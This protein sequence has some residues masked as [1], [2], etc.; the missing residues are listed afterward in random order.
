[1]NSEHTTSPEQ[2]DN[3]KAVEETD[4]NQV[5]EEENS[6]SEGADNGE[7]H[8]AP[9]EA[10]IETEVESPDVPVASENIE[11]EESAVATEASDETMSAEVDS[12]AQ[13]V[14]D[15]KRQERK[16]TEQI[17]AKEAE[18]KRWQEAIASTQAAMGKLVEEGVSELEK[19][20]KKLQINVEQL[21]R[22]SERIKSEMRTN[23]AGVSQ[24]LAIRI[25][26]FKD[27]L[28]GSLQELASAAEQ[29]QLV[30]DRDRTVPEKSE[31]YQ[32]GPAAR[33]DRRRVSQEPSGGPEFGSGGFTEQRRQIRRILDQYR[34][35]PD[36]YGPA[37]QLRRTFEPIHAERVSNWFFAQGGKG[38]VPSMG[39]RLQNILITSAVI[40]VL[41]SLYG[42][43]LR[44]LILVNSPERL[45]EWRRGLQ[46]CLG[47]SR[48]DFGSDRG[49]VL[50]EEPEPLAVKAKRLDKQGELPLIVVDE[51]ENKVSLSMLQF[52]L[53][54]AFAAD[55]EAPPPMI[56]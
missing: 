54:L 53:W 33:Q 30:P 13:R 6:A 45:G 44:S 40:S 14:A 2:E 9:E 21:E 24:D 23:F 15:L 35:Q 25:Q 3:N 5:T 48:S 22:R 56:Y 7:E 52:L 37:W 20:K 17:A 11:A 41:R 46:D 10:Y 12:L 19:R 26:G 36:Y 1:M 27:Y 51:S 16:I 38:A 28:V 43:R 50:F 32:S 31:Y 49:I 55:P 8:Q 47:I 29:L 4:N 34:T 42:D 39:S 18:F